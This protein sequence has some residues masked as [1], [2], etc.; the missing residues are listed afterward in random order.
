MTN[1]FSKWY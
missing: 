1:H